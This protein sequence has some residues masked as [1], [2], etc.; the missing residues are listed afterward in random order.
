MGQG[1]H[2]SRGKGMAVDRRHGGNREGHDPS[3]KFQHLGDEILP[4]LNSLPHQPAQVQPV[5]IKFLL[6]AYADQR[7][8]RGLLH[9]IERPVHLADEG[10]VEPVLPAPHGQDEYLSLSLQVCDSHI[11]FF[12]PFKNPPPAQA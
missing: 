10:R 9:F 11:N 12:L 3:E 6:P 5:G 2:G 8:A 1:Q 7:R 4:I